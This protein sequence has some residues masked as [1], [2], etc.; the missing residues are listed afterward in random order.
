M[1][2]YVVLRRIRLVMAE[3]NVLWLVFYGWL[4]YFTTKKII[5]TQDALSLVNQLDALPGRPKETLLCTLLLAFG[6][7]LILFF[8]RSPAGTFRCL[9]LA[10]LEF[11][12]GMGLL[13]LTHYSCSAV[14]LILAADVLVFNWKYQ[15]KMLATVL[16]LGGYIV[17]GADNYL[18]GGHRIPLGI[19]LSYLNETTASAISMIQSMITSGTILVFMFYLVLGIRLTVEENQRV[20]QLNEELD[21]VNEDLR[22]ANMKLEEYSLSVEKLS[23]TRERNRLAREIHDT[24]GH[25]L[26]GIISSLD[27]CLTLLDISP[28]ET[29]KLLTKIRDVAR[30]GMNDVRRTVNALRPDVLEKRSLGEAVQ[31]LASEMRETSGV[32][33]SCE[34]HLQDLHFADDEEETIYRIVQESM[35]NAISH[36]HAKKIDIQIRNDYNEVTVRVWDNGIG[37]PDYKPGYG[38]I[39]MQERIHMLKGTVSFDGTDGFL[40][41]A[42]IPIRWGQG[43]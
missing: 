30:S 24:L 18:M 14:M 7:L 15:W 5:Q 23:E 13:S 35:T 32:D 9:C 31:Q 11:M 20:R 17:S 2:D 42:K 40:V 29:R 21:Q 19:Y 27:A 33:I 43:G 38:L 12:L 3:L 37:C 36:G 4:L 26:T 25:T 8:R 34:I 6:L 16:M 1:K 22:T 41:I 28:E 10:L 39:H